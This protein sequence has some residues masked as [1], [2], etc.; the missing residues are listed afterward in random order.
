MSQTSF[1]DT[2]FGQADYVYGRHPNAFLAEHHLVFPKGARILSLGEGEGRNA[3]FLAR[4]GYDLTAMDASEEG[5]RKLSKLAAEGGVL[6]SQR[7]EDV[8]RADLGKSRWNGIVNVFCHLPSSE[9]WDL[10]AR[11][12]E[13]LKPGGVFLSEMFTPRQ[14][15]HASGGPKDPD[16]LVEVDELKR[17]FEG[18]EIVLAAEELVTLDEGPFHQGPASVV[19]FIARK[20]T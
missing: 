1:W 13:A 20:Q 8:T 11:I 14:L 12:R 6:V 15:D 9:R 10:Y 16:L 4:Q 7:Q 17:A 3:V 2:R 5:M 18:F 19:R